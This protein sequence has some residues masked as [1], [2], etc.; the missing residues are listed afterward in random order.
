MSQYINVQLSAPTILLDLNKN[1]GLIDTHERDSIRV[2]RMRY[3][4]I[5]EMQ[6]MSPELQVTWAI[7]KLTGLSDA[8][9]DQLYAEDAAEITKIIFSFVEKYFKLAKEMWSNSAESK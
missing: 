4:H 1:E 5:K 7:K 3:G 8:D 6:T 2:E 9:I